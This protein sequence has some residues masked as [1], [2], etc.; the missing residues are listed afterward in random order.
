MK[1]GIELAKEWDK[2]IPFKHDQQ[3]Y[4]LAQL[5]KFDIPLEMANSVNRLGSCHTA[6]SKIA[7][8]GKIWGTAGLRD[9]LADS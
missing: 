5:I 3:L 9:M 8:T 6:C 1:K 4:A 7:C 2:N